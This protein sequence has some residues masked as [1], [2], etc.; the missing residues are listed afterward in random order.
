MEYLHMLKTP[1]FTCVMG[2]VN[3]SDHN[4]RNVLDL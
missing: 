1:K 4:Q 3:K 2:I